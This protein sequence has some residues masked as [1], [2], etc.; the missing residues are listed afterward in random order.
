MLC[1]NR[2]G[3]EHCCIEGHRRVCVDQAYDHRVVLDEVVAKNQFGHSNG[4]LRPPTFG[5]RAHEG[6][7][8][9]F[10][11]AVHHIEMP[12]VHGNINRLANRATRMMQ[13]GAHIGELYEVAE[14][15][16]GRV[17]PTAVEVAHKWRTVRGRQD[18]AVAT[19]DDTALRI[20][21]VLCEF[22]G[23]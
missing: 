8:A 5:N 7:V 9:V 22:G 16:N 20:S 10:Q 14:I 12:F 21:R 1:V 15:L 23:R 19:D 4:I 18:H 17:A 6:F 11:M 2:G 13:A 3:A